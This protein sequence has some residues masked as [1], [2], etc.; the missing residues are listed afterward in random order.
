MNANV[1]SL[2]GDIDALTSAVRA[3]APEVLLVQAASRLLRW[4]SRRAALARQCGLVVATADRP[5]GVCVMTAL[6]VDLIGTSF[7]LLPKA[8]G[9]P[10]RSIVT[11]TVRCADALWRV[12]S[13]ELGTEAT[14]R[15]RLLPSALAS[16]AGPATEPLV[17]GGDLTG[18]IEDPALSHSAGRLQDCCA[19]AGSDEATAAVSPSR[20]LDTILSD[21]SLTVISCEVVGTSG[22]SASTAHQPVLVVLRRS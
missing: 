21:S 9:H 19:N 22:R 17:L 10:Q 12:S 14:E 4:R 1:R 2:R 16:A 18:V 5:G 6:R 8:S 20:Q 3:C 15:R 7:S 13:T 11:A